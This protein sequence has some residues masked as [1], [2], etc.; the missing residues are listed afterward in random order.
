[1]AERVGFEP[2]L[3]FCAAKARRVRLIQSGIRHR[4]ILP[5]C[6]A[7]GKSPLPFWFRFPSIHRSEHQAIL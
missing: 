1:M 5:I 6:E 4:E 2:R 3:V 7:R